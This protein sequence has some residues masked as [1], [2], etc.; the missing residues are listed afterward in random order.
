MVSV[1]NRV[2]RVY[3]EFRRKAAKREKERVLW[4][5]PEHFTS[6]V[7]NFALE[8]G[9][10]ALQTANDERRLA[11]A[12]LKDKREPAELLA[13]RRLGDEQGQLAFALQD[14]DHRTGEVNSIT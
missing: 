8:C 10:R 5:K 7:D 1:G 13:I 12:N 4:A 11:I 9:T 2:N 6:G 14:G 3:V